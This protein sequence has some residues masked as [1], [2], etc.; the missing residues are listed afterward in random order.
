VQPASAADSVADRLTDNVPG[1]HRAADA[2]RT[3]FNDLKSSCSWTLTTPDWRSPRS[4]R[5]LAASDGFSGLRGLMRHT[6]ASRS[7]R[8]FA[9][10]WTA[11]APAG[12]CDQMHDDAVE[13]RA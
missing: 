2:R 10:R 4:S 13:A 1:A 9:G 3:F 5:G 7:P 6:P 12:D 11:I 8:H